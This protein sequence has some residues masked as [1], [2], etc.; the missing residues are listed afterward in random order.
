MGEGAVGI[1]EM[2][3]VVVFIGA[4]GRGGAGGGGVGVDLAAEGGEDAGD[5]YIYISA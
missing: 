4:G 1:A 5:F 3:K 2:G